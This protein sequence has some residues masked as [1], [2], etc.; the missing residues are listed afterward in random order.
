MH[1]DC[2]A[3][4]DEWLDMRIDIRV[5]PAAAWWILPVFTVSQSEGGFEKVYQGS[6]LL[7]HWP[8]TDGQAEATV[9]LEFAPAQRS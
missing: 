7:P 9:R 6:C 1:G 3:L 5:R 2:L 8:V 4:V